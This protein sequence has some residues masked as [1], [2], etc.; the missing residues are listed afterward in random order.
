MEF[1]IANGVT[2]LIGPSGAGKSTV[3]QV[4]S[5]LERGDRH[6]RIQVSFQ[7]ET[8]QDDGAFVP[9]H[10][11]RVGYVFQHPQLFPHLT[12]LEN[13]RYG[14]KRAASTSIAFDDVVEWL[15]L[16]S[17]IDRPTVKL[18]G[19]EAQ[20]VA[21]GRALLASPDILLMD[22]PLGSVDESARL[23][24]LPYLARLRSVLNI[25]MVYVTHAMQEVSYLADQVFRIEAGRVTSSGSVFEMSASLDASEPAAIVEVT[26]TSHDE[27][28]G[29]AQ[30]QLGGAT[31]Y[32][33]S[34]P[35][36]TGTPVRIRIPS[37]DVSITTEAPVGTSI[38]NIIPTTVSAIDADDSR[39]VATVWLEADDTTLVASITRRS[40]ESLGLTI[41]QSVYAQVKGVALL[42]DHGA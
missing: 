20:R 23:R 7:G 2:A 25:P 15:D 22:E 26:V 41:G 40:L 27:R 39:A 6:D 35:L 3:L 10:K 34:T 36:P 11:R 18:S 29:L 17:L 31:L 38:L 5:G 24:I 28:Y 42:T 13:L 1:D 21:I 12:V 4:L 30:F 16:G 19:G 32:V 14:E 8:W 9:P 33:A 37:R